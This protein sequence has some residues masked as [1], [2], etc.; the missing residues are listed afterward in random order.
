VPCSAKDPTPVFGMITKSLVNVHF[1]L[2]SEAQ[3]RDRAGL[4][5]QAFR[6]AAVELETVWPEIVDYSL[7]RW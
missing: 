5:C 2:S 3:L 4:D 7:W 6:Q 1:K